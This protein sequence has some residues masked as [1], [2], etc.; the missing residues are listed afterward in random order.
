[1][2]LCPNALFVI[3]LQLLAGS[4]DLLP[5]SPPAE[6]ATGSQDQAGQASTGDGCGDGREGVGERAREA[7]IGRERVNARLA[8]KVGDQEQV[9]SVPVP[10]N[11]ARPMGSVNGPD[12]GRLIVII[13]PA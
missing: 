3:S 13:Y 5:P 7:P 9:G 10:V 4:R 8:A 11:A 2:L 12:D 1:M 6:K